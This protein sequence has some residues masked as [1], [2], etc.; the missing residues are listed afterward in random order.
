MYLHIGGD[1]IINSKKILGIFDME[2]T[3]ISK[4]TR[5]FLSNMEKNKQIINTSYELPKSFIVCTDGKVYISQISS[6][7]LEKRTNLK[8]GGNQ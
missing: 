8:T 7:T 3:T 4:Y 5:S 6:K 2:N 1:Y